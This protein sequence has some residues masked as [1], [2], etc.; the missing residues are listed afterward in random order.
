VSLILAS[1]DADPD[2]NTVIHVVKIF[3]MCETLSAKAMCDIL[4]AALP[5]HDAGGDLQRS[6]RGR[7]GVNGLKLRLLCFALFAGPVI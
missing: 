2:S 5:N 3:R 1:D 4:S 6:V 7:G